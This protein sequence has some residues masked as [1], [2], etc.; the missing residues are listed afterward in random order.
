MFV[1]REITF[2][3]PHHV[4]WSFVLAE[5]ELRGKHGEVIASGYYP[6]F[7]LILTEWVAI[8]A[9]YV[10]IFLCLGDGR[11]TNQTPD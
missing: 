9:I 5:P 8:A 7:D 4:A 11:K 2:D 3:T 1:P 10:G 6:R